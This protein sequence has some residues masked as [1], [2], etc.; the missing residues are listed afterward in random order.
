M[1]NKAI[2]VFD[3]G[4]GGLT[5][6]N[7]LAKVLPNE[8]LVYFGDTGRVPYGSRSEETIIKYVLGDINFLTSCDVKLIVA[9]CGTASTVALPV[10]AKEYEIPVI[11]VVEAAASAAVNATVNG[12]IGVIGTAGTIR[13]GK[14]EELIKAENPELKT[15]SKAC[16]LFVPL[17]ENGLI[18]HEITRLTCQM[19]L[20]DIKKNGVDTLILGC[21]HYPMLRK[22]IGEYMGDEVALIDPGA[23][24]A[25]WV[26]KLLAER[27]LTASP[28]ST[29]NS[30]YYVSDTVDDFERL[31]G[32]FMNK[33]IEGKVEKVDI[34]KY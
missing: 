31:A 15:F 3:S 6:V 9:A 7:E 30:Q 1:N 13:N 14:Y 11:G 28:D 24:T 20:E 32:M 2:G 16:P 27:N 8:R 18:E 21:T 23:E 34:E 17:V 5:C 4:L 29:A 10:V 12:K 33:N 22:L 25:H 19:Y 26:K